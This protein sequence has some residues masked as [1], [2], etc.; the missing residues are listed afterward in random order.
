MKEKITS[1]AVWPRFCD[2]FPAQFSGSTH[3]QLAEC[4]LKISEI[5]LE[6]CSLTGVAKHL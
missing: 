1:K 4:N 2:N 5:D 3:G 6:K